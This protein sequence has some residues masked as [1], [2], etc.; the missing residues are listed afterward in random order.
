MPV[1]INGSGTVTGISV[2]GLPN[3]IVDTDMIASSVP[4]GVTEFD[5]WR[6]NTNFSNSAG[7]NIINAGW[8]RCDRNYDKIGTGLTESSGVFTFPATGKYL[9]NF[10]WYASGNNDRYI[11]AYIQ[12]S[13]DSGSNY[14][15]ISDSLDNAYEGGSGTYSSSTCS[16]LLDL[17]NAST[18]RMRFEASSV[19]TCAYQGQTDISRTGFTCMRVGGT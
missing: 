18:C 6:I 15:D 8:E 3:G 2:G 14:L 1:V 10:F 16:A 12:F 5:A 7:S 4:L 13:T 11:G 19:G 17:T 9:V